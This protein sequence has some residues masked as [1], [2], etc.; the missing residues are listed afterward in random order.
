M[1][2]IIPIYLTTSSD[3]SQELE[4]GGQLIDMRIKWNIR[5]GTPHMDFKDSFGDWVYGVKVVP[6]W[7]LFRQIKGS[8]EF[9]GDL[10]V[11]RDGTGVEN[12][13]TYENFGSGQNLYWLSKEEVDYWEVAN[14][15]I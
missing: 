11:L 15:S 10:M 3:F 4:L 13:I 7:P 2:Q 1:A 5:N 12:E 8:M 14:G 9:D 6:Y